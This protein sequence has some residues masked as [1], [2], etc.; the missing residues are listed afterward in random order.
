MEWVG[1]SLANAALL[2]EVKEA[3]RRISTLVAAVRSYSQ[4]D[5]ASLQTTDLV[6]GLDST[7][8][9][10]AHKLG[11][12]IQVQKRY[13]PGLPPIEAM[14]G[15]LNQVWTN[16]ADR[17]D[18]LSEWLVDHEVDRRR[19]RCPPEASVYPD[20]AAIVTAAVMGMMFYFGPWAD[21]P[22]MDELWWLLT[23]AA[24]ILASWRWWGKPTS[25]LITRVS[26]IIAADECL[27]SCRQ[28][29]CAQRMPHFCPWRTHEPY[30]SWSWA[31]SVPLSLL[32]ASSPSHSRDRARVPSG[33]SPTP[34]LRT[35][36]G[37]PPWFCSPDKS[38]A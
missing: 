36:R 38:G 3:T 7:L 6:E 29:R 5:R 31:V 15:E 30:R 2:R 37:P 20:L 25:Y 17:E 18:E 22:G 35:N 23:T 1:A 12:R 14:A 28:Q 11:D 32:Q 16:L 4:M 19:W 13:A 9:M 33:G 21:P 27:C 24:V 8:V 10:L 26:I 34:L